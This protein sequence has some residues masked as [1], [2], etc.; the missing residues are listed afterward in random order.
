MKNNYFLRKV[1]GKQMRNL[2]YIMGKSASGKDTVYGKLKEELNFNS[3]I[4]YTTR[5]MRNGEEQGKEYNFINNKQFELLKNEG[6]VIEA[7]YYNVINENSQKDIWI[8]ATIADKQLEKQ[9]DF[10]T[11]G[12]LESYRDIKD[13]IKLHQELNLNLIPIYIFV[14]E[15]ERKR[16]AINREQQN[17][18]PNYEEMER[19]LKK[20]NYDFSED[21]IRQSGI[22]EK[23]MFENY[24]LDDCVSK[25]ISYIKEKCN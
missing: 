3:Y 6:K 19:R 13:Y 8:Y 20:D 18:K 23:E 15:N 5:P 21:K 11:I 10:L 4:L 9:G 25:I 16:R 22:S 12:T 24:N 2:F 14:D 1:R 17:G 7:R